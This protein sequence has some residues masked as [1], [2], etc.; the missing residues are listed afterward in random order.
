MPHPQDSPAQ[1]VVAFHG[2][3]KRYGRS[4]T[5]FLFTGLDLEIPPGQRVLLTGRS[6]GGKTT[7]LHLAAGLD[8]PTEGTVTVVGQPIAALPESK[9]AR[10]R[11]TNIGIVFQHHLLPAGLRAW[12]AVALPLLWTRGLA[13]GEARRR[14]HAILERLALAPHADSPTQTL[15]GGQRQRV[16]L[17]RA[18]VAAPP[19]ILA[20]EPTSNLDQETGREIAR[21][22]LDWSAEHESTLLVVSHEDDGDLWKPD[23]A[24]NLQE[25]ELRVV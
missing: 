9:R 15:S 17:A 19:L 12:E 7:L 24:M 4:G 20:D 1:P 3:S 14:A 8:R 10:W 6:G 22:L 2:V 21:V 18:L 5:P 13:P 11:A 23:V 25:G 16:A